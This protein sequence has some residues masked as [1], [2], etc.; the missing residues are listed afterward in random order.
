MQV[1]GPNG[2]AMGV[3]ENSRGEVIATFLGEIEYESGK[4]GQAYAYASTY[5]ATS[6]DAVL[7]LLNP[8]ADGRKFYATQVILGSAGAGSLRVSF[9]TGTPAAGAVTAAALHAGLEPT[10]PGTVHGGIA[11]TGLTEA[12]KIAYV[13]LAASTSIAVDLRGT[14][15]EPGKVLAVYTGVSAVIYVSLFGYWR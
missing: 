10:Q 1:T 9:A 3:D 7:G 6:G 2:Q 13:V 8:T 15:L 12:A 5:S 14:I 11:V 4:T